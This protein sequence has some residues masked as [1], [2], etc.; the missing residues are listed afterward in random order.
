MRGSS[1]ARTGRLAVATAA[2]MGL[3]ATLLTAHVPV[4]ARAA[5]TVLSQGRSAGASSVSSRSTPAA[6]AVDGDGRTGWTSRRAGPQWLQVSIGALVDVS[7]VSVTWGA[8]PATSYEIQVSSGGKTWRTV[9]ST[10]TGTG[11][12][13]TFDVVGTGRHVRVLATVSATGTGYS[14]S[15]LT[16]RGTPSR[17]ATGGPP[18]TTAPGPSGAPSATPPVRL[19]GSAGSWGLQVDGRPFRVEGVTY[20]APVDQAADH[21]PDIASLGAN[22][23]RTWGTDAGSG[24]LFDAAATTGLH[25]VA[26]LWLDHGVDYATDAAYKTATLASIR[27][28]VASYRDRPSLLAWNVG[29]EVMLG[30]GESRRVAYARFVDEVARTIH[31]VDPG[32]PVTSTDAWSGA[33]SY[34]EEHSPSL[35]FYSVNSYGGV[36]HLRADW[37]AGG[38]TKPYL[39]TETGPAGSW[40]VPDDANGIPLEPGDE[41]KARAYTAA[42]QAVLAHPGVALGA[43]LFNYGLENDEPG[44]WLNLRTDGLRRLSYF[45]VERAYGGTASTNTS[46]VVH[47]MTLTP[48]TGVRPGQ[49]ITV[50]ASATDPDGDRVTYRVYATS[51]Y[52]DGDESLRVLPTTST[53]TGAMTVPAPTRP[54]VWKIYVYA[55]DGRGNVGIEARSVRVV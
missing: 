20:G 15:E 2:A 22:T 7:Q 28:T 51:R 49:P 50:T 4:A 5:D 34:Y 11:G 40:E 27:T 48:S 55:L 31:S 17:P 46:P 36:G 26:G 12:T 18:A 1:R 54:G 14:L 6:A 8:A 16:V 30:Q 25:V 19:I 41:A 24:P 13:E 35:D 37:I 3:M 9:A 32:H 29:N 47:D 43:T 42:W 21:F 52:V 44:V 23:V 39:V 38:Y 53:T 45:A 10:T 33:F